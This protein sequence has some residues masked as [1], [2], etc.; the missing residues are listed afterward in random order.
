MK[1]REFMTV[2]CGA[3]ASPF[4]AGAQPP[5]LGSADFMVE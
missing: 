4:V 2:V 5:L 3:V 1:R